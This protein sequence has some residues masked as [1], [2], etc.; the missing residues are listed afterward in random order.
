MNNKHVIRYWLP[1]C[2][3]CLLILIQ[4]SCPLPVHALRHIDKPLHFLAYAVLGVLVFRAINSLPRKIGPVVATITAV[5]L[6][7]VIGFGDEIIQIFVPTRTIDRVDFFYDILGSFSGI[8][9][10]VLIILNRKKPDNDPV[11]PS[12][13]E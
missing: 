12:R 10:Y 2:V 4:A 8:V 13:D 11:A 3:Y 1:L 5:S 7:A 6:S 9:V